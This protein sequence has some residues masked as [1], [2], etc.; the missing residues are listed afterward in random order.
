MEQVVAVNLGTLPALRVIPQGVGYG[1]ANLIGAG[2]VQEGA[3]EEVLHGFAQQGLAVV[4]AHAGVGKHEDD[5]G[6]VKGQK[7]EQ[8]TRCLTDQRIRGVQV[9]HDVVVIHR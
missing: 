7:I 1:V 9:G 4:M 2:D 8:G 3:R 6:F 5:A